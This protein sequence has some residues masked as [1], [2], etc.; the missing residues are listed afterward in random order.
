M[1]KLLPVRFR[2]TGHYVPD[3][4]LNN[5]HFTDYLDTSDEWIMTR[6]GIRERRRAAPEEWT[7]TMA[8]KAARN[9]LEDAGLQPSDL[10]LII[11][12]TA[13][14]D[15]PLPSTAA[16]IQAALGAEEIPAFDVNAACAGFLYGAVTAASFISSGMYERVLV[17]GAEILT[18]AADPQDRTT[19]VLFGD[20]AGAAILER[21]SSTEQGI[22]YFD[23][24]CDGTRAE[25]IWVPA[26]GSRLPTSETTVA[27]RLHYIRMK[28]REVYKFAVNKLQQLID[29]AL[30]TTNLTPDDLKLVIPHQSNLR[31][32]ESAR[33]RMGLPKDKI[34][35]N[36]D[37]YGNTSAAS[38]ILSLDEARR[39]G[40]LQAGDIVLLVAIGAGLTWSTMIIRL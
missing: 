12:A 14:S 11:C 17:V 38:V 27:E 37:R 40:T 26:G 19:I 36:I 32:I 31:I 3:A 34:A 24:G 6:T 15:C 29:N 10:D 35:V 9:A 4:V 2:G 22:L 20:A 33:V 16:F 5:Q 28:G 1:S 21:S 7:S 18:R 23:M 8:E 13:T 39:D 30:E 25:H